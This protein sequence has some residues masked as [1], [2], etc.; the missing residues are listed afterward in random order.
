MGL[1]H[2]KKKESNGKNSKT[3]KNKTSPST[4]ELA[5]ILTAEDREFL[6][7]LADYVNV[8]FHGDDAAAIIKSD[9]V[10]FTDLLNIKDMA[11]QFLDDYLKDYDSYQEKDTADRWIDML[12]VIVVKIEVFEKQIYAEAMPELLKLLEKQS[13]QKGEQE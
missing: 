12:H 2:K 5:E 4:C 7:Y 3:E 6:V 13:K 1:F 8:T 10:D 9:R 11:R